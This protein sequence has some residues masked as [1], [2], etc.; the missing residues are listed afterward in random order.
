M[1]RRARIALTLRA[2]VAGLARRARFAP[3]AHAATRTAHLALAAVLCATCAVAAAQ[4]AAAGPVEF[5]YDAP[6]VSD[7]GRETD[8]PDQRDAAARQE[9]PSDAPC[10]WLPARRSGAGPNAVQAKR[11]SAAEAQALRENIARIEA[12]FSGDARFATPL[13]VCMQFSNNG[14]R[15]GIEGGHALQ[16]GLLI[17]AWPGEWLYRRNGRLV[18]DGETRHIVGAVNTMPTDEHSLDDDQ[19]VM[20]RADSPVLRQVGTHQ[21]LPV[22]DGGLLVIARN[23]R[24]LFRPASF[25]RLARWVLAELDHRQFESRTGASER[26]R[27][28]RAAEVRRELTASFERLS[29]AE[30]AAP[31]C[32]TGREVD[33][34]SRL[35]LVV[36]AAD[37]RCDTRMV[38]PNPEYFDRRLPRSAIQL[39]TLRTLPREPPRGGLVGV[40]REHLK[41]TWMNQAIFWGADWNAFR[42][43][44]LAVR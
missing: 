4:P 19:G 42:N 16:G 34:G 31:G 24:P 41:V 10:R 32:F 14:W 22:Y 29:P 23:D 6:W 43:T 25:E 37:P 36:P 12:F 13:G 26:E 21:G 9:F 33:F 35:R 18:F 2:R 39:V 30:R 44:V 15:G 1:R 27:A 8:P 40:R 28:A 7:G 17:G 38:E 20:L 5:R 11:A 3:I